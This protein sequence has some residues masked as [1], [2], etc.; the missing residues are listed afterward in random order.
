MRRTCVGSVILASFSSTES[1][2]SSPASRPS[3]ASTGTLI[4][5]KRPKHNTQ[6]SQ[7]GDRGARNNGGLCVVYTS[8]V[9]NGACTIISYLVCE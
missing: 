3:S 5:C 1:P 6:M 7:T 8:G 9:I 2:S 4:A